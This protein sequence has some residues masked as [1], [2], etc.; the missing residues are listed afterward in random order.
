MGKRGVLGG[1]A[2]TPCRAECCAAPRKLRSASLQR[3]FGA[4]GQE[5]LHDGQGFHLGPEVIP[6][7]G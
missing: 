6:A 5:L 1:F 7:S 2:V 4:D 3:C